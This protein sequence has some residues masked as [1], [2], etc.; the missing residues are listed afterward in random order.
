MRRELELTNLGMSADIG[1]AVATRELDGERGLVS[2]EVGAPRQMHDGTPA[3]WVCGMRITGL[4]PAPL[5][6]WAPGVDSMDALISAL[7][8]AGDQLSLSGIRLTWNGIHNTLLPV[9]QADG[10]ILVQQITEQQIASTF[11]TDVAAG[12]IRKRT[13]LDKKLED[14]LRA[15]RRV[16]DDE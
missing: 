8:M 12:M 7:Q 13:A 16:V 15:E 11:G 5:V 6:L 3:A 9:T 10:N 4:R 1:Q 2:V 14:H